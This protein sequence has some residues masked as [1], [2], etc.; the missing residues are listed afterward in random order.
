MKKWYLS[1]TVLFNGLTLAAALLAVFT[2]QSWIMD[3]N[4][5]PY[6]L[7]AVAAINVLLRTMT[8]EPLE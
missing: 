1:K 5:A 4:V 8:T 6:L 7:S 2:E 3:M